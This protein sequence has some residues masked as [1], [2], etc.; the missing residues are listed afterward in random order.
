MCGSGSFRGTSPAIR[1]RASVFLSY[2]EKQQASLKCKS[3]AKDK[4]D[5]YFIFAVHFLLVFEKEINE[6]SAGVL[7]SETR[8]KLV[9]ESRTHLRLDGCTS[10]I[11]SYCYHRQIHT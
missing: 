5:N 2:F 8:W 7:T 3:T 1:G 9:F 6:T 4:K 10:A 11:Y